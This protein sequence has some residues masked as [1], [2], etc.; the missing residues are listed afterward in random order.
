MRWTQICLLA[1][2]W[3]AFGTPATDANASWGQEAPRI[4]LSPQSNQ[5]LQWL[6]QAKYLEP[7]AVSDLRVGTLAS[8]D[9]GEALELASIAASKKTNTMALEILLATFLKNPH[10]NRVTQLSLKPADSLEPRDIVDSAWS[11]LASILRMVEPD[12]WAY[13]AMDYLMAKGYLKDYPEHYFDGKQALNRYQLAQAVALLLDK[14]SQDDPEQIRIMADTLRAEF[15]DQIVWWGGLREPDP[16]YVPPSD[17][18]KL[19]E[20][21]LD[22]IHWLTDSGYV[23]SSKTALVAQPRGT[24]ISDLYS[25]LSEAADRGSSA[26]NS[27]ALELIICLLLE[28]GQIAQISSMQLADCDKT[29]RQLPDDSWNLLASRITE[30]PTYHWAYEFLAQ[31]QAE[32]KPTGYPLGYFDGSRAHSRYELALAIAPLLDQFQ[33]DVKPDSDSVGYRYDMLRS[34]FIV[35]LSQQLD[36]Q[37]AGDEWGLLVISRTD[38]TLP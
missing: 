27:S 2:I 26:R 6:V 21:S 14:V 5:V 4:E 23:D 20:A 15:S 1:S 8:E 10:Y 28:Y 31:F 13:N 3:L 11:D 16:E 7:S 22:A 35:E 33:L 19:D 32:G 36:C 17:A 9:Y 25:I 30:V 18:I 12:H 38:L 24:K 37:L 29:W 34:E